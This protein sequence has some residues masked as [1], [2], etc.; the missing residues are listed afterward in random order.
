MIATCIA[1]LLLT[2]AAVAAIVDDRVYVAQ[3]LP[4]RPTLPAIV[5]NPID[6]IPG[7][8][9]LDS[10]AGINRL[11][12]QVDCWEREAAD[13][14]SAEAKVAALA[15]AVNGDDEQGIRGP[16]HGFAGSVAGVRIKLLELLVQAAT[17]YEPDS[18]LFRIRADYRA[19]L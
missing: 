14:K 2:D 11:R 17:E 6:K 9:T 13:G 8:L 5:V 15:L 4:Q 12:V 3:H 16:L 1:E 18:K 10:S 7:P 19:H